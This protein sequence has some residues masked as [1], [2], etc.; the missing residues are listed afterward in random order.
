MTFHCPEIGKWFS[1]NKSIKEIVFADE[2]ITIGSSAFKNCSSLESVTIG[3]GVTDI[4]SYAFEGCTSLTTVMFHCPEIKGWFPYDKSIK[5]VIIGNEVTKISGNFSAFISLTTINID[6]KN[7]VY[8][9]RDNCNGIIETSS[10]TLVDGCQT[11]VIPN[12]VTTIGTRAFYKCSGL[13]SV[14]I[15]NS[16]TTIETGAFAYCSGLT[17]VTIPNSVT[18]IGTSAF[19]YCTGMT[20]INIPDYI[21]S[22]ENY[23]F[24]E[25]TSLTSV[26]I[27]SGVTNIAKH[28]FD[29]CSDLSITFHCK[30]IGRWF[31]TDSYH[32]NTTIKEIIVGEG[33]TSIVDYA[34]ANHIK[35]TSVSIG[36]DLTHIGESAFSYCPQL[37]SIV[38]DSDNANYDSRESCNAIIETSTNTLVV[39]CLTTIIPNSVTSI[40]R[41]AFFECAELTSI[42]IPNSVTDIDKT[43]FKNCSNL[44]TITFHCPKIGEWFSGYKG[45]KEILEPMHSKNVPVCHL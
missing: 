31:T 37:T 32:N 41:Y 35:L 22:I 23:T 6:S 44:N 9:S 29:K 42:V 20:S 30:E 38:V 24:F 7:E 18:T 4:D 34:F 27:G 13:T 17:S 19:E 3:N 45:I 16:V 14:T 40:G 1:E 39:G 10:N 11:T 21:T 2:V 5:E 12:S 8:D 15:P 33:V 36:N 25:C 43:A 28:A 26:S